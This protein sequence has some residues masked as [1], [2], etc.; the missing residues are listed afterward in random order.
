MWRSSHNSYSS[1]TDGLHWGREKTT[2]HGD[3]F[4]PRAHKENEKFSVTRNAYDIG[5]FIT[6]HKTLCVF[7][8]HFD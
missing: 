7:C 8:R 6:K 1:R 2:R 5:A 4:R 3:A